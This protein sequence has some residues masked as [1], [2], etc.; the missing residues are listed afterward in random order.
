MV[1]T[2]PSRLFATV[3][4]S[5]TFVEFE[6]AGPK[7]LFVKQ[8]KKATRAWSSRLDQGYSQ[9]IDWFYKLDDRRNSDDYETRFGKRSIDYSGLLIVG[10]DRYMNEG[11]RLRLEWRREHVIVHS[12]KIH[13]VTFDE[14][15]VDLLARLESTLPEM[16]ADR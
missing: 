14:L 13:C 1:T 12:R 3:R 7:S 6:D 16:R 15:A 11:E 9:I 10:R 8:G 5:F 2:I 4:K